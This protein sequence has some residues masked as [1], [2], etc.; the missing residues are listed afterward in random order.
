MLYIYP[1]IEKR[2]SNLIILF[3]YYTY[4]NKSK[5]ISENITVI[6][7]LVILILCVVILI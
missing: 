4:C 1:S 7:M 2:E 3:I 5:K 6:K